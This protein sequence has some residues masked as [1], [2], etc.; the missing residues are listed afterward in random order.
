M[1]FSCWPEIRVDTKVQLTLAKLEPATA[2]TLHLQGLGNLDEA[3]KLAKKEARPV[4][5]AS[6]YGNL[7]VIENRP[8]VVHTTLMSGASSAFI[9][10]TL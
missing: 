10:T 9:P 7:D 1:S 8:H 2:S 6:W 4:L 5:A 3:Q